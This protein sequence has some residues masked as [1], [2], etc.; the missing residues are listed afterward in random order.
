MSERDSEV[1]LDLKRALKN[2]PSTTSMTKPG[3]LLPPTEWPPCPACG[4]RLSLASVATGRGDAVVAA[5]FICQSCPEFE[6][7]PQF[8]Y[9]A[10]TDELYFDQAP[11]PTRM[12]DDE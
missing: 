10:A 8:V 6:Y 7:T 5:R 9:E 1:P 12:G 3:E 11:E 4:D 2:T